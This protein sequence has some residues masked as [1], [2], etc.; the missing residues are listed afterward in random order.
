MVSARAKLDARLGLANFEYKGTVILHDAMNNPGV[1][2]GPLV[3]LAGEVIGVSGRIVESRDTNHQV[4]YAIPSNTLK[5]FIEDTLKRPGASRIFMRD[6]GKAAADM[7]PDEPGYHGIQVLRG[8]VNRATPA[9]INR[10]V[11]G[12][13]AQA[14]CM[15]PSQIRQN[16]AFVYYLKLEDKW[17]NPTG[18]PRKET[19]PGL[20]TTGVHTITGED[21][22][23]NLS[24]QSNP[25][26]VVSEDAAF[27]K[28][29]KKFL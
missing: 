13:P 10:V 23:E 8:G 29:L 20:D 4:H 21:K 16:E 15:A 17:G 3:S 5:P 24:S 2:G 19:H 22:E 11:P 7:E 9:Y 1:Y 27:Q 18:L 6:P 12:S 28:G 14:V 26:D 25:I